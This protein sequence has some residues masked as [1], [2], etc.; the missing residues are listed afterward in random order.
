MDLLAILLAVAAASASLLIWVLGALMLLRASPWNKIHG[1]RRVILRSA[2][3]SALVLII[4]GSYMLL[5]EIKIEGPI[6]K[7]VDIVDGKCKLENG[8]LKIESL[9][10]NSS[11]IMYKIEAIS[12]RVGPSVGEAE[13]RV[14][15]IEHPAYLKA[16]DTQTI[17]VGVPNYEFLNNIISMGEPVEC[18]YELLVQPPWGNF[19]VDL[20]K[21]ATPN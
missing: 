8:S 18:R 2:V 5:S 13:S 14:Y 11:T 19:K 9:V 21:P 1:W 20:V 7:T 4:I 12:V 15:T 16:D 10:H 17:R 6:E 3:T